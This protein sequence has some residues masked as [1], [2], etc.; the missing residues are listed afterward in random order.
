M[1]A[2]EKIVLSS[3]RNRQNISWVIPHNQMKEENP[4]PLQ[5]HENII[6]IIF[7]FRERARIRASTAA[8]RP[9]EIS[10]FSLWFSTTTTALWRWWYKS[11]SSSPGSKLSL[12]QPEWGASL[13]SSFLS[14]NMIFVWQH[15][16][17][18]STVVN[19]YL[20]VVLCNHSPPL[21]HFY[22]ILHSYLVSAPM[23][24]KLRDESQPMICCLFNFFAL[25]RKRMLQI[26]RNKLHL[27]WTCISP[28]GIRPI[29]IFPFLHMA[30]NTIYVCIP[31]T[32]ACARQPK[33]V[34]SNTKPTTKTTKFFIPILLLSLCMRNFVNWMCEGCLHNFQRLKLF[35]ESI[36]EFVR[37]GWSLQ[38]I[39]LLS[40]MEIIAI[41]ILVEDMFYFTAPCG[42][43][44]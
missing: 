20:E 42:K 40:E 5:R 26:H 10:L 15:Y 44:N 13:V 28:Q 33:K 7:Y 43:Y 2:R 37:W 38:K 30:R 36:E 22:F 29:S 8:A 32:T 34:L 12:L 3:I 11:L 4:S 21:Y 41:S 16:T 23:G 27:P 17:V 19:A 9:Y 31:E 14:T 6:P 18:H 39:L 1:G 25:C 24:P 35:S